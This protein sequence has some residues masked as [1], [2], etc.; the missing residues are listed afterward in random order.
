M[1]KIHVAMSY[2]GGW[3]DINKKIDVTQRLVSQLCSTDFVCSLQYP[4]MEVHKTKVILYCP[5]F[6]QLPNFLSFHH[7]MPFSPSFHY[8]PFYTFTHPL[9]YSHCPSLLSSR[10]CG[11]CGHG[12]VDGG[13]EWSGGWAG[14]LLWVPPQ[15][16]H[17][18]WGGRWLFNVQW[19]IHTRQAVYEA[20]V[21]MD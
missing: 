5:S 11:G 7:Y 13:A 9:L 6:H 10:Q 17:S 20:W 12:Q 4:W 19:D 15:G 1:E 16:F 3:I 14:Q 2:T 21:R 18:F 8:H